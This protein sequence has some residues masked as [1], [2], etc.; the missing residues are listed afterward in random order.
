MPTEMVVFDLDGTLVDSRPEIA[1]TMEDAWRDVLPGRA[2]PRERLRIGPRL[3]DT[4]A[5]LGPDLDPGL[6]GSIAGE[7]RRR[8]DA[9][10]FSRTVPYAGIA[11]VLQALV[12]RGLACSV[13]TNKRRT[14]T[15]AILSRWF[16][17][18]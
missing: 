17:G 1:S 5:E 8:Y 6:R 9:S 10:D 7:F 3:D 18:C 12:S 2:F 4:I 15:L 16:S 14:P 11:G 13:A